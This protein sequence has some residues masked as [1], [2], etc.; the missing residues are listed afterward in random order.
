MRLVKHTITFD[1]SCTVRLCIRCHLQ[2]H[3]VKKAVRAI[4]QRWETGKE[5]M[6]LRAATPYKLR[7]KLMISLKHRLRVSLTEIYSYYKLAKRFPSEK[8]LMEATEGKSW[9]EVVSTLLY[10]KT[11]K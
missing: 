10:Q 5:I 7:M 8:Q 9:H 2:A 3:K 11:D 1:P 4:K 6:K